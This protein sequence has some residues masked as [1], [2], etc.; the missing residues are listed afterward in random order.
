MI[1]A[2]ID[3]AAEPKGTALAL[4]EFS[5]NKAKLYSLEQGLDDNALI[6]NT[7]N[8]D[9]VGIDC[10]FGWPIQFAQFVNNHQDLSNKELIDGGMDYRRELS[11]RETDRE[12]K[13][14]TGRWPLSVSTDRLGL[15]AIRCAGLLSKYQAKGIEIDRSGSKLLVEVYPGATLRNWNFD[16]TGYRINPETRALLLE[17]LEI[18]AP[19]LELASFRTQMIESADSFDAVIAALAAR[20]VYQD[21]YNKPTE[22]QLESA[23]VEGWICLPDSE[24]QELFIGPKN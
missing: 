7:H 21:D 17:Q 14:L 8:A 23:R 19:W 9:K 2:G 11:F 12:I 10:A 6:A 4:I 18:Q 15:T 5:N 24:L 16:T 1:S 13:R 3:L 22:E 20:A